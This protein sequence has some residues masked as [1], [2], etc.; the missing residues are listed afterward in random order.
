MSIHTKD[1]KPLSNGEPTLEPKLWKMQG[2]D[3]ITDEW[4]WVEDEKSLFECPGKMFVIL[5][6][7]AM[8]WALFFY[9]IWMVVR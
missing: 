5:T 3:L 9:M 2:K 7:G 6:V 1:L 8:G 4:E